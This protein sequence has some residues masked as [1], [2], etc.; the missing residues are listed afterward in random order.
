MVDATSGITIAVTVTDVEE[1]GVVTLSEDEPDTGTPLTATLE[2]GDGSVSGEEWQ[3]ARSADGRSNWLNIS[4]ATASSYTPGTADEDFY[5]RASVGYTDNRGSGKRAEGVTKRPVPSVNRRP[6][7][8]DAETGERSV[9]ENLRAGANIG[10]PVAAVDPERNRLTYTLT[11]TDAGAF[12]VV[13][14][15]GQIRRKDAL[16]FETKESYSLTV[17]V[18]D[19]RDGEG[20]ASTTTDATQDVTITVRNLE[21]AG[22]VTLGTATGVI[23]ARVE[24]TA[25]AERPRRQ[26][27]RA[28]L[29]VV[30]VAQRAH[31]LGQRRGRRHRQIHAP[32]RSPAP[33]YPRDGLVHGRQRTQQDHAHGVSPR[34]AEPPPV[35]SAPV[36]PPTETGQ[37]EL[38]EDAS[39]GDTI[40]APGR[41][42]RPQR[43][44]RG[45]EQPAEVLAGRRRTR[46]PSRSMRAPRSSRWR[47]TWSWT[48]RPHA[49]TA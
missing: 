27:Q 15:S 31:Q 5:L 13:A 3:W 46:L 47:K 26:R 16:D 28:H 6:A 39:G 45:R 23:Q 7:F 18:H 17:N 20:N 43:R 38:P 25:A 29:A 11:G 12:D 33:L 35:N 37:R 22:T 9:D 14:S 10:A 4:A 48:T 30:P 21:E 34:V 19:G 36:F 41:R 44:R 32:G 24:V 1:D 49:P 8:P 40:G 42:H 2:D